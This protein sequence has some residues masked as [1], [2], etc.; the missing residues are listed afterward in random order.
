[1]YIRRSNNFSKI[2]EVKQV[3]NFK[4]PVSHLVYD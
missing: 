4:H 2:E 1:M 3:D